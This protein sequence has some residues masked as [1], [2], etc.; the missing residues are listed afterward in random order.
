VLLRNVLERRRELA[1]LGAVGFNARH[2]SMIVI[3]ETVLLLVCGLVTGTGCALV[4]VLPALSARGGEVSAA[5]LT[6][7]LAAVI[8]TGLTAS[9]LATRAAVRMPLV[10]SLR[11]E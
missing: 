10:E 9:I 7:L 3:S 4:A 2:V 6:L 8:A 11:T 5:S 1:L